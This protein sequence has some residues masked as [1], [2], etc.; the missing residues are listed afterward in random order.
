MP[1]E[2]FDDYGFFVSHTA[3]FYLFKK[4]ILLPDTDRYTQFY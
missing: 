1:G 3:K 2:I 4:I